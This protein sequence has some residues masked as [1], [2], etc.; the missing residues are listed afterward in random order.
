MYQSACEYFTSNISNISHHMQILGIKPISP[1][2]GCIT[3]I[4]AI[5]PDASLSK[6]FG[7]VQVQAAN[8]SWMTVPCQRWEKIEA[9][10]DAYNSYRIVT[11]DMETVDV[12]HIEIDF[13]LPEWVPPTGSAVRLVTNTP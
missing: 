3:T 13:R 12:E 5:G 7:E 8:G 2:V 6:W 10:P 4:I 9:S 1:T 11:D